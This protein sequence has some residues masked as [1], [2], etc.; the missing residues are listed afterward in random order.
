MAY[1][2]SSKIIMKICLFA[3]LAIF[4]LSVDVAATSHGTLEEGDFL[5]PPPPF[6]EGIYPCS[7]C[8]A[9]LE[10]NK[11]KR[12]LE[13]HQ[14]IKILNH[15]EDR[16]WCLDCHNADDRDNLRLV[17]GQLIPFEKSY[18]LCGQCHGTIFRDWRAGIHG[19]RTGEWNGTKKYR[20]CAHCHNP[21]SPRFRPL[22]PM[23]PPAKPLKTTGFKTKII[24]YDGQEVSVPIG[25]VKEDE[26]HKDKGH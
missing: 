3:T 5:V 17:S 24:K 6:S 14:E 25:G 19:R 7:N 13:F 21:H 8:H 22:K 16:R 20:L 1:I 2:H 9:G 4:M 12:E 23:P 11:T 15:A 10:V 18:Y 26:T